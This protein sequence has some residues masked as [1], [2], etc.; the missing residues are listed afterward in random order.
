ME[1]GMNEDDSVMGDLKEAVEIV[2]L[3]VGSG[4]LWRLRSEELA[5]RLKE[6]V[7]TSSEKYGTLRLGATVIGPARLG[8]TTALFTVADDVAVMLLT[9]V[10]GGRDVTVERIC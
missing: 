6:M 4:S 5:W 2:V 8:V 10:I 3:F 1:T 7:V 9:V